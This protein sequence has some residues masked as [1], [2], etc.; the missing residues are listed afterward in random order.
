MS[1]SWVPKYGCETQELCSPRF[2]GHDYHGRIGI[3]GL[4][5]ES[6]M[7]STLSEIEFFNLGSPS[8]SP[9]TSSYIIISLI[10]FSS[11]H[12]RLSSL[13]VRAVAISVTIHSPSKSG[14][15]SARA[16]CFP[17]NALSEDAGIRKTSRAHWQGR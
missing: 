1:T 3:L 12:L 10:S 2:A 9:S 14:R 17:G 13:S 11:I 5:D 15:M 6:V 16:G 4:R 7:D 8:T